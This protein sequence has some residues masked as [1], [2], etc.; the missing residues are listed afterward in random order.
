MC[1]RREEGGG[2]G[3]DKMNRMLSSYGAFCSVRQ[4]VVLFVRHVIAS[5]NTHASILS[6]STLK[7]LVSFTIPR[8]FRPSLSCP[9]CLCFTFTQL[10]LPCWFV[11]TSWSRSTGPPCAIKITSHGN[12]VSSFSRYFVYLRCILRFSSSAL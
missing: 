10:A 6:S 9:S 11:S 3:E 5:Y 12:I 8:T 7:S 4:L 2:D 1:G